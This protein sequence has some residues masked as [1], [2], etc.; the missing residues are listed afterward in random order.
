M[1]DTFSVC[2][3]FSSGSV[4]TARCRSITAQR[5]DLM[6][7]PSQ[8][9]EGLAAMGSGIWR[10]RPL[11]V[12]AALFVLSVDGG[13]S[14]C[15]S[16]ITACLKHPEPGS[17]AELTLKRTSRPPALLFFFFCLR[18]RV[19]RGQTG[20]IIAIS[21]ARH[22]QTHKDSWACVSV[23]AQFVR[24]RLRFLHSCALTSETE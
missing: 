9:P 24:R 18:L 3:Q 10:H 14:E 7:R 23:L 21:R 5:T 16:V 19:T 12:R 20:S 2:R 17:G 11:R 13:D 8:K 15:V 6:Q 22:H 4:Q 1:E